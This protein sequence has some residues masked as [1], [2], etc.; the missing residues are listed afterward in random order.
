[1][2]SSKSHEGLGVRGAGVTSGST[3]WLTGDRTFS[4]NILPPGKTVCDKR[5]GLGL[6]PRPTPDFHNTGRGREKQ[7]KAGKSVYKLP[8]A[9]ME[10][11]PRCPQPGSRAKAGPG[12]RA[13]ASAHLPLTRAL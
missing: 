11:T 9:G 3:Q 1:M 5:P 7:V 10:P 8:A 6:S 13:D 2:F 12:W 4:G